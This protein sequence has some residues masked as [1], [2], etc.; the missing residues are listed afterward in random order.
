M[1]E[2]LNLTNMIDFGEIAVYENNKKI[3]NTFE[4]I[5]DSAI[6]YEIDQRD[7][8]SA[9]RFSSKLIA[10]EWANCWVEISK[11]NKIDDWCRLLYYGAKKEFSLKNGPFLK[12]F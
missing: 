4:E 7:R 12:I 5:L 2:K 8:S 1:Y 3:G 11:K 9:G 10:M 6:L